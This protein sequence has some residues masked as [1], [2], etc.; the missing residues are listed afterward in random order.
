[1]WT[2]LIRRFSSEGRLAGE[3]EP[4]FQGSQDQDGIS[5]VFNPT[6]RR[7]SPFR[8]PPLDPLVLQGYRDSTTGS[9]RLLSTV[10]AEE[11]RAMVPE[12]LRIV[13]DWQLL[14]S[15]EQDG[16]SLSTLYQ[17]CR[18]FDG[19]RVGFVIVVK[20][21]E[22][23]Y[24]TVWVRADLWRLSFRTSPSSPEFLW[25]R[26][27]LS[28]A[29]IDHHI[30]SATTLGRYDNADAQSVAGTYEVQVGA[31]ERGLNDF[32][33]NCETGFLSVGAGGGHYGLWLDDSLEV[34]H[35]SR[36]ETFGNEA[37]SDAGE[38]FGVLGV[39][40]WVLGA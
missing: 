24:A 13:E 14:Y 28:L 36:C 8:P 40:L 29:R 23:G 21:Q 16:A 37:L 34:G 38:K 32:F 18:H 26:G 27:V 15:L 12:R 5:G 11:I 20:D 33:I 4:S 35:S 10:L 17:K 6:V 9:A 19:R 7:P 22:G 25:Q 39:E 30:P 31:G 2:G 1:M 3:S